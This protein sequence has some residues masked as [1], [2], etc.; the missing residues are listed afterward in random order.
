MPESNGDF[1]TSDARRFLCVNDHRHIP[2]HLDGG[3]FD[4]RHLAFRSFDHL[5][6]ESLSFGPPQVHPEHMAAQSWPQYL[7]IPPGCL[8]TR[9][10]ICLTSKHTPNSSLDSTCQSNRY[11]PLARQSWR[12]FF[13]VGKI[14]Q[15]YRFISLNGRSSIVA[16]TSSR[17]ARSLPAPAPRLI[18]PI[19]VLQTVTGSPLISHVCFDSQ[20]YPLRALMRVP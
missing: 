17:R 12:I 5:N 16:T 3:T 1:R 15:F 18:T 9:W 4:P 20:R 7:L 6:L 14:Q 10:P 19:L 2:T 13:G 8:Q 11:Q